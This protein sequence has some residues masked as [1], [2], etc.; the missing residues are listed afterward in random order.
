MPQ[1]DLQY[2]HGV[3]FYVRIFTR[4][5]CLTL[6]PTVTSDATVKFWTRR[7]NHWTWPWFGPGILNLGSAWIRTVLRV[8]TALL[9]SD[10]STCTG[11]TLMRLGF[12]CVCRAYHRKG[13]FPSKAG[14][15][16]P[17]NSS[18]LSNPETKH[19]WNLLN[20]C[21]LRAMMQA[22]ASQIILLVFLGA[23]HPSTRQLGLLVCYIHNHYVLHNS[24]RCDIVHQAPN[25]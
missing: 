18:I 6:L 19:E 15:S 9:S 1:Q 8:C 12:S 25:K 5:F 24:T 22:C 11:K 16:W 13:G 20:H 21:G 7:S 23:R 17:N 14:T 3:P 10:F 4:I 2:I